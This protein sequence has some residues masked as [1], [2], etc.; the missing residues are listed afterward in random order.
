[1]ARSQSVALTPLVGGTWLTY[2][3]VSSEEAA[4]LGYSIASQAR[5]CR[6]RALE[7]GAGQVE[8]YVDDGVPGDIIARPALMALRDRIRQGDVVGLVC[9][10]P[11][12]L[13]RD[14]AYQL[15]LADEFARAG[16]KL[17][18]INH[19]YRDTDE[20]RLFFQ[21][22]GAIAE[23]ERRKITE[24]TQRGKREKA[25]KGLIP[26]AYRCYGYTLEK[27]KLLVNPEHSPWV[28]QAFKWCA[29]DHLGSDAI[30]RRLNGLGVP[31]ESGRPWS[32]QAVR[33]MLTNPTY[34]GELAL[35][36][37]QSGVR[38]NKFRS[39]AERVKKRLKPE[40]EWIRIA[41]PC[42]VPEPLWNA[43][44]V[45]LA[46]TIRPKNEHFYPYLLAGR[47]ECGLCGSFVR[48]KMMFVG[49]RAPKKPVPYYI[50][51]KKHIYPPDTTP[52]CPLPSVKAEI[53]E[54]RVWA[55][56]DE[57]T[58][59]SESF[60]RICAETEPTDSKS[61]RLELDK[62]VA[63][64][65]SIQKERKEYIHMKA[66]GYISENELDDYMQDI[67]DRS[68]KLKE[69]RTALEALVAQRSDKNTLVERIENA[70]SRAAAAKND[71]DNIELRRQTVHDLIAKVVLV[72][73]EILIYPRT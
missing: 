34:M 25:R 5:T 1:M 73:G 58:E 14:L 72:D 37:D 28:V 10:D 26:G 30:A 44:Q 19:E 40:E 53:V 39:E 22:R 50:C 63:E 18:F 43:V 56:V 7:L 9:Y 64:L 62:V 16:V 59:S 47:I 45:E 6:E 2:A 48:G 68:R 35:K 52:R 32:R 8:E 29:V 12:R 4:E 66:K 13:A 3:R 42:L 46:G 24:R 41:V 31:S 23:F 21:I 15:V 33:Y 57:W 38:K 36:Y 65:D 67:T 61:T 71:P 11:D 55:T 27:G 54:S 49:R 51:S 17:E 60:L 69:R 70:R 20:G